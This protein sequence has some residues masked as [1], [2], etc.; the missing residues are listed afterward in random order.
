MT[1]CGRIVEMIPVE[2]WAFFERVGA[3]TCIR[4]RGGYKG[5]RSKIGDREGH[6]AE[7]KVM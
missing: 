4:R 2:G 6:N 5:E 3:M 7:R 1:V